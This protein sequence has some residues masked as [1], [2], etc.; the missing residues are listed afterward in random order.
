MEHRS[1]A[2]QILRDL[3]QVNPY[4]RNDGMIAY[5]YA[6]G[7]LAGY[8]ASLAEED[9]FIYRRFQKHVEST[10]QRN[11]VRRQPPSTNQ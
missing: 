6:A 4:T 10:R 11:R 3:S 9:P 7:F 5:I 1:L 8:L 2:N